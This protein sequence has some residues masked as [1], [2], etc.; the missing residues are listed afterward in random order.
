[1]KTGSFT[2]LIY[3]LFLLTSCDTEEIFKSNT[4]LN[5]KD[6]TFYKTVKKDLKFNYYHYG[7][8]IIIDHYVDLDTIKKIVNTGEEIPNL[9]QITIK[10]Q[11][12]WKDVTQTEPYTL[13]GDREVYHFSLTQSSYIQINLSQLKTDHDLFITKMKV[14]DK[15]QKA[16][17]NLLSYSTSNS[18]DREFLEVYANAGDYFLIVKPY[19]KTSSYHL[20]FSK[21]KKD[22]PYVAC[23]NYNH[24]STRIASDGG[25]NRQSTTWHLWDD[26]GVDGGIVSEENN[27]ENKSVKFDFN[28]F[29]YQDVVKKLFQHPMV[30]GKLK[31]DF[32]L[33]IPEGKAGRF[34]SEKRTNTG[35]KTSDQGFEIAFDHKGLTTFRQNGFTLMAP[36]LL[37]KNSWIP[38]EFLIDLDNDVILVSMGDDIHAQLSACAS[39]I[40]D[41]TSL[42]AF[43][44]LNFFVTKKNEGYFIDDICLEVSTSEEMGKMKSNFWHH[45]HEVINFIP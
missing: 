24:L 20:K 38:V 42:L 6:Y 30:S 15:G 5:E 2:S 7:K 8:D 33:Y 10:H 40:G 45:S 26:I 4:P 11:T 16:L 13:E 14:N 34:R 17:G 19:R 28:D 12:M 35:R 27:E 43:Y 37:P 29:G 44:G 41:T 32:N 39:L 31:L 25:I 23:E 1:M 36:N 22:R 3:L 21:S 9:N 18:D